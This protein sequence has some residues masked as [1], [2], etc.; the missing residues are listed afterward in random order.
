MFYHIY[1]MQQAALTP[2]RLVAEL[3][4]SVYRHP[5]NPVSYTQFGR[6]VAANAELFERMTRKFG[7]PDFGLSH[8]DIDGHKIAVKEESVAEK[9]FCNLLHFKRHTK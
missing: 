1:E 9:P 7:K 2:A 6:A 8:T 5:L 4:R 3:T